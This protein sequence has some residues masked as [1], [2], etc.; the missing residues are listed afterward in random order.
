MLGILRV[1]GILRIF[2]HLTMSSAC[3]HL[4]DNSLLEPSARPVMRG[5]SGIRG[6][7]VAR[8]SRVVNQHG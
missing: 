2:T 4:M 5:S 1:V 7:R 6:V 3:F 8:D